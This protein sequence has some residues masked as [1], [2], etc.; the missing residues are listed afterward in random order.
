MGERNVRY[1]V[2]EHGMGAIANALTL[3]NSGL[4]SYCATFFIFTDYMRSAM[5]MAAL[6]EIGTIFVM[7]H[8]SIGLGEDG[9]THQPVE[10]IA[11]F[12]AMPNMLMMRPGDG[13]ETAGAYA[14]AVANRKR[15][16]TMALSRQ[17]MPNMATTSIEGVKKGAYTVVDCGETPEVILIGTGSELQFAVSAGETLAAEGVKVNVVSMPCWELYE[18]QTQEYKDSV[19]IP[20]VTARVSIEA[21]HTMG[22]MKYVGEKGIS[23]GVDTF[24]AS[25]PGP[26]LYEEYGITPGAMYTAAK[27]LL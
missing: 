17:G 15:P 4:I 14:V 21:G 27:S 18:E 16:T 11:S 22:W 5:R 25:A 13:N 8:D 23:I 24:G 6:S 2:R 12:R 3:H 19:L 26:K 1:G 7:T 20:G 9:P 10:H